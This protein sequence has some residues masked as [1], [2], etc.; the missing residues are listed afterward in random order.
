[1]ETFATVTAIAGRPGKKYAIM[2]PLWKDGLGRLGSTT[3]TISRVWRDGERRPPKVGQRVA[4]SE[5]V[6]APGGVRVL[7]ARPCPV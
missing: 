1:M 7:K 2:Y 4:I 6:L 3:F 5:R